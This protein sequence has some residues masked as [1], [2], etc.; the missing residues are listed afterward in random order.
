MQQNLL[1]RIICSIVEMI[2]RK[3][4]K[5]AANESDLQLNSVVTSRTLVTIMQKINCIVPPTFCLAGDCSSA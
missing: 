1:K 5:P 2:E 3:Y 4:G